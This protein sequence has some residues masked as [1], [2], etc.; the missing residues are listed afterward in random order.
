MAGKGKRKKSENA[1]AET[2]MQISI[3]Q[4]PPSI[5][6]EKAK[7]SKEK[8]DDEG[9]YKKIDLPIEPANENSKT[10]KNKVHLFGDSDPSPDAWVKWR[11]EL[12]EIIRDCPRE[13]GDN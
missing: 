7:K 11:I 8:S 2:Q 1:S 12:N 4:N 6:F 3:N 10:I 9:N 13:S 5:P